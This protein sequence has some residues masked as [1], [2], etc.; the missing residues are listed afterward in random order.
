M[1]SAV[2]A[3]RE[4]IKKAGAKYDKADAKADSLLMRLVDSRWT[5]AIVVAVVVGVA[6]VWLL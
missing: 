6:A 2:D 1:K 5:L 4:R 3:A